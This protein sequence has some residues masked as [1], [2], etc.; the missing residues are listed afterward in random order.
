M[1]K[2]KGFRRKTRSLLRKKPRER[3]K[4]NV[5][6]ILYEYKPGEKVVIKIDPS[7]HKGM[8]HRRYHG[9]VGTVIGKRGRSYVVNVTQGDAVKKI[10]VRPEHLVPWKVENSCLKRF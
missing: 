9:N 5:T 4:I 8:P 1:G 6:K 2:S 7:I 3:G 10:I